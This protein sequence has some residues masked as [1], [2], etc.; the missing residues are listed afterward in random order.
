MT[1]TEFTASYM[2]E[3]DGYAVQVT[4]KPTR[5]TA[6]FWTAGK[7]SEAQKEADRLIDKWIAQGRNPNA[8][9]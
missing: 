9:S 4:H 8:R 7:R 6:R 3:A 1:R 5:D 2:R